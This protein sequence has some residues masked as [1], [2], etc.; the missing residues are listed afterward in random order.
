MFSPKVFCH[1]RQV[2]TPF[3]LLGQ[4]EN[5]LSFALGYTFSKCPALLQQFLRHLGLGGLSLGALKQA[6]IRL[7]DQRGDG[8]TDI[9]INLRGKLFVVIEAKVGLSVPAVEQCLK[10]LPRF[11]SRLAARQRL[12]SLVE[13]ASTSFV[14]R[15]S[16]AHPELQPLLT[17]FHWSNL[18]PE[19]LRLRSRF[20][21][22][23][24]E[25]WWLR[26]FH[27]FLEQ[28]YAM[29]AFTDEVWIVP[30]DTR[31]LWPGGISFYE[32]HAKERIYFRTDC[33]AKRPL[34]I[35]LRAHG[36]VTHIQRVIG[37]E[38]EAQP[39]DFVPKLQQANWPK[40]PRTIW[41]LDE[42]KP[43]P[44]PIPTGDPTMRARQ[45]SCDIDILLSASSVKDAVT[46]MKHRRHLN[47]DAALST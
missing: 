30:A 3:G 47:R 10:Y 11:Q 24:E 32:T 45:F 46:K 23:T 17:C 13:S 39:E 4:D 7:Q 38:H 12:V 44:H 8:I 35:A 33:H 2:G 20:P 18:I 16:A 1:D 29:R 21:R 37:V 40:V 9:E 41:I 27:Q 43:L 15:Y 31:P 34:Y 42:P 28:E 14:Q 5:A 26:A 25:G 36:Q 6:E 19:C 22:T